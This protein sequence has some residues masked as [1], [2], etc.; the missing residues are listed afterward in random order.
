[1]YSFVLV[2][3]LMGEREREREKQWEHRINNKV[4]EKNIYIFTYIS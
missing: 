1:M 3:M 4:L 2:V